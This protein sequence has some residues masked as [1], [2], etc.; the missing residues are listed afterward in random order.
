MPSQLKTETHPG[1]TRSLFDRISPTKR[2]EAK[3]EARARKL[4]EL[5]PTVGNCPVNE[6][7]QS[8]DG[9]P[10]PSVGRCEHALFGGICPRHGDLR[11]FLIHR[12]P[13][14]SGYK[15]EIYELIEEDWLPDRAD[16][17]F[18]PDDLFTLPRVR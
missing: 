4:T 17:D 11:P 8:S 15:G 1:N 5:Y 13:E 7:Q 18:G 10:G 16:R 9:L 14:A 6:R 3:Q 12:D 2:R